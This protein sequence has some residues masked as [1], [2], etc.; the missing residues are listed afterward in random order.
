MH[1]NI[2]APEQMQLLP[3]L[4]LFNKKFYLVGGTAIAL[5]IGHRMSIDFDLFTKGNINSKKIIELLN[6]EVE[7]SVTLQKAYQLNLIANRVKMTFFNFPYKMAH[8][9]IVDDFLSMPDLLSLAAMKTFALGRRAKWKDYVDLYF[10]FKY[11][12]S[13]SEVINK[14]QQI[15]GQ[16]FVEKQFRAQL[17]YFEDISF[18]EQVVYTISNP[19]SDTEIKDFLFTIST[20]IN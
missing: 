13:F 12:Y 10:I 8:P 9:I 16:E 15:F 1:K 3:L 2:L 11:H 20:D 7:V 5:Q 6:K 14:T 18:E 4:K 19:P 17:C